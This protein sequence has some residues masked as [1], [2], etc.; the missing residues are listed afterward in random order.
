[1][2]RSGAQGRSRSAF[3]DT[4]LPDDAIMGRVSMNWPQLRVAGGVGPVDV[5][6][7]LAEPGLASG[8]RAQFDADDVLRVWDGGDLFL[9]KFAGDRI[10]QITEPAPHEVRWT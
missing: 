7:G 2:H 4:P 6:T 9:A 1:R 3:R 8:G 5:V 10:V